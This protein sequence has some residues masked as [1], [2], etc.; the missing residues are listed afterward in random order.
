M[1]A[2]DFHE[3]IRVERGFFAFAAQAQFA[4]ILLQ[5][6]DGAAAQLGKVVRRVALLNAAVVFVKGDIQLPVQRVLN[7]PVI[8]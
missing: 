8:A 3:K 4:A 5:Q 1:A 7:A 2:E 6:T